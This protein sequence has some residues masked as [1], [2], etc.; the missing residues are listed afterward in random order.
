MQIIDLNTPF[1]VLYNMA[2][3]MQKKAYATA[4][5]MI[6]QDYCLLDS[7]DIKR[8]YFRR[9]KSGSY[10]LTY[11]DPIILV[12]YIYQMI[13]CNGSSYLSVGP[14]QFMHYFRNT[15][16]QSNTS[17]FSTRRGLMGMSW[18]LARCRNWGSI[19]GD[20]AFDYD[21]FEDFNILEHP[22][23]AIQVIRKFYETDS[24][25]YFCKF[26]KEKPQNF[27]VIENAPEITKHYI[28][29]NKNITEDLYNPEYYREIIEGFERY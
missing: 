15:M 8:D 18:S 2:Q 22:L 9:Y 28:A 17:V 1:A 26:A 3:T 5:S 7:I 21:I 25:I 4:L 19:I 27:F 23:L 14:E 16:T 6:K 13:E 29:G 12:E 11:C 10:A 24:R 20:K